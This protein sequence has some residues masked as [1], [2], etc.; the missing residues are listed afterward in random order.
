MRAAGI[1]CIDRAGIDRAATDGAAANGGV[2]SIWREACTKLWPALMMN[3]R[4]SL[5]AAAFG[6]RD[7]RR[8]ADLSG[9]RRG[10]RARHR[11]VDSRAAFQHWVNALDPT[12]PASRSEAYSEPQASRS[13]TEVPLEDAEDSDRTQ[14]YSKLPEHIVRRAEA[15]SRPPIAPSRMSTISEKQ[16]QPIRSLPAYGTEAARD[17]LEEC[18]VA[19]QPPPDLLARSAQSE[20]ITNPFPHNLPAP[21]GMRPPPSRPS[22]VPPPP[23][24]LKPRL[25]GIDQSMLESLNRVSEPPPDF[26]ESSRFWL[27]WIFGFLVFATLATA[28]AGRFF[29]FSGPAAVVDAVLMHE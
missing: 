1:L 10:S 22:R 27:G 26:R 9:I 2:F 25:A 7:T 17:D 18:T 16:E 19:F 8:G 14:V 6:E 15:L 3:P 5:L 11:P 20:C 13:E 4:K 23:P 21:L 28:I 24:K 12:Q 29:S